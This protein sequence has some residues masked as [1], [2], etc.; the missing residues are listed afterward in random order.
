MRKLYGS[1]VRDKSGIE[2]AFSQIV[3]EAVE[4]SPQLKKIKHKAV[5]LETKAKRE[6]KKLLE[7]FSKRA[8]KI[9]ETA[10]EKAKI[11]ESNLKFRR[12][13]S[14]NNFKFLD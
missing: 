6:S 1:T 11:A 2:Q 8:N 13:K 12:V 9:K 10:K 7:E 3:N 5:D 4:A 14:V